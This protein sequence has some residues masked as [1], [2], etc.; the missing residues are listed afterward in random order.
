MLTEDM[1]RW[2]IGQKSFPDPSQVAQ[3]S[4]GCQVGRLRNK[5]FGCLDGL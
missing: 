5:Y 2:A 4:C 3:G 1:V